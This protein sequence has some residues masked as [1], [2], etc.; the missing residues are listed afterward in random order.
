MLP[1]QI[2]LVPRTECWEVG[3]SYQG[4]SCSCRGRSVGRWLCA[5]KAKHV[6]FADKLL[7]IGFVAPNQFGPR[8]EC[9]K[10]ALRT[11]PSQ[12]AKDRMLDDGFVAKASS[13]KP[14]PSIL[15]LEV[16][17]NGRLVSW[18]NKDLKHSFMSPKLTRGLG[19]ADA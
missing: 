8:T 19:L 7:E 11:K 2:I 10:L 5:T 1:R 6:C 12:V 14:R 15:Y 9:L 16:Q 17:M 4:N 13:L 3:L 18:V